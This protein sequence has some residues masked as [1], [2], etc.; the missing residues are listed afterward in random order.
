MK[1][2]L[3]LLTALNITTDI[4]IYNSLPVQHH[5][6]ELVAVN[7][8]RTSIEVYTNGDREEISCSFSHMGQTILQQSHTHHCYG[9]TTNLV[10]PARVEIDIVNH[11]QHLIQYIVRAKSL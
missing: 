5:R 3:P 7:E 2:L 8:G 11:E 10:L 6:K 4:T 1:F 9:T